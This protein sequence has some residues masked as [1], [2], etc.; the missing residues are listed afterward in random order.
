VSQGEVAS[1]SLQ[2]AGP[3]DDER[4]TLTLFLGPLI[5]EVQEAHGSPHDLSVGR[6]ST[7]GSGSL[8]RGDGPPAS[9]RGLRRVS[10]VPRNLGR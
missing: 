4:R 8:S 6:T 2:R 5:G 7:H 1:V 10:A 9:P 3:P